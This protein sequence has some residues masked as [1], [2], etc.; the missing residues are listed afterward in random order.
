MWWAAL[1]LVLMMIGLSKAIASDDPIAWIAL[2]ASFVYMVIAL[3][4]ERDF[5]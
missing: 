1:G 2:V 5:L 4:I 3:A